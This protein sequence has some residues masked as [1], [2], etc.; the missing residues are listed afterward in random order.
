M[1]YSMAMRLAD[2]V[3]C[4]VV[5]LAENARVLDQSLVST[6]HNRTFV[7]KHGRTTTIPISRVCQLIAFR[8]HVLQ[9]RIG[10]LVGI[11]NSE[12]LHEKYLLS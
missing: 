5:V 9:Y 2:M 12:L 6:C 3:W 8:T 4:G 11:R 7:D 1:A 10:L